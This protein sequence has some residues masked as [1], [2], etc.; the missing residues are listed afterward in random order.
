MVP[1]YPLGRRLVEGK[2][3]GQGIGEDVWL[4]EHLTDSR[5]DRP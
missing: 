3:A 1:H 4:M 5:R 2:R